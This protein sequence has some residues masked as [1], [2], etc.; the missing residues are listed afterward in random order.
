MSQ[1]YY[2]YIL[3]I[4]DITNAGTEYFRIVDAITTHGKEMIEFF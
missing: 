2:I 3:K 1:T 4:Y